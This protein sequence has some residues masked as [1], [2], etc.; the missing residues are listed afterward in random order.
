MSNALE[1]VNRLAVW[2][3][4]ELT[5]AQAIGLARLL[6][7]IR[8]AVR[9]AETRCAFNDDPGDFDRI[10]NESAERSYGGAD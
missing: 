9:S 5:Q 7:E 6:D 3:G 2:Q 1:L 8:A 4:I 10:L